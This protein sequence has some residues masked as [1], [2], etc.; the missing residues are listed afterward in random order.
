MNVSLTP[1][2]EALVERRVRS[3]RYQSAS[4]VVREALRL[5]EDVEELRGARLKQLRRDIAAGLKDLDQ[6]R[7][8]PL[9]RNLAESIKAKGRKALARLRRRRA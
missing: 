7:S 4:E 2:L 5:L 8:V 3:G 9:D 1:E 6:G